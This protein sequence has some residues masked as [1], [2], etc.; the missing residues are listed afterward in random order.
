M[1][2]LAEPDL[3]DE[4]ELVTTALKNSWLSLGP[5]GRQFRNTWAQEHDAKGCVLV[6][7]GTRALVVALRCARANRMRPLPIIAPVLTWSSVY[8]A[9]ES[10][11]HRLVYA[12]I[13][14]D[15][16]GIDWAQPAVSQARAAILVHTYGLPARLPPEDWTGTLIED[17][18]EA[19]FAQI[20][21]K[22]VG[23]Y[24][25]YATWSFYANKVLTCGEG[26]VVTGPDQGALDVAAGYTD[27]AITGYNERMGELQAAVLMAQL[28]RRREI[29]ASRQRAVDWY[30]GNLP[31]EILFPV[32]PWQRPCPW[33]FPVVMPSASARCRAEERLAAADVQYR[34]FFV[35]RILDTKHFPIAADMYERGLVLPCHHKLNSIQLERI[36]S[37]LL[38]DNNATRSSHPR[39]PQ[40]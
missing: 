26:G 12:D 6:S 28:Q 29:L 8:H 10:L 18:A 1:I 5:Y 7:N 20:N 19:P 25:H 39:Q 36:A 4:L 34:R 32:L 33:L 17:C 21:N 24:G 16:L 40:I 22:R 14:P 38:D 2:T 11:N 23:S 13:D 37:A 15:T 9:V 3:Q 35:P 30:R 27:R 31:S